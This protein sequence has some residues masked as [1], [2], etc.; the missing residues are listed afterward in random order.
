MPEVEEVYMH[1]VPSLSTNETE[2]ILRRPKTL[3]I[4]WLT[5]WRTL[6]AFTNTMVPTV[7]VMASNMK[8]SGIISIV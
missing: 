1:M 6:S 4:N 5:T 7:T 8:N 3:P 2:T